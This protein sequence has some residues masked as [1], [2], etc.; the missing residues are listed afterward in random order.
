M[1]ERASERGGG[2]QPGS[3]SPPP[4]T[5]LASLG[6]SHLHPPTTTTTHQL[7]FTWLFSPPSTHTTPHTTHHL[8]PPPHT[9]PPTHP[10]THSSHH[11]RGVEGGGATTHTSTHTHT[12]PHHP[13]PKGCFSLESTTHALWRAVVRQQPLPSTHTLSPHTVSSLSRRGRPPPRA[14]RCRRCALLAR[15]RDGVAAA[16]GSRGG[17]AHETL[18]REP[19]AGPPALRHHRDAANL[20]L[21]WH[22][23]PAAAPGCVAA[24]RGGDVQARCGSSSVGGWRAP[25]I[26][27]ASSAAACKTGALHCAPAHPPPPP[28]HPSALLFL[29]LLL[30]WA[31]PVTPSAGWLAGWLGGWMSGCGWAG[32]RVGLAVYQRSLLA[33][34]AP[35]PPAPPAAWTTSAATR[36]CPTTP[37]PTCSTTR[38]AR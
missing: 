4:P 25:L 31:S 13:T 35:P 9:H 16:A 33:A 26:H 38:C 2:G 1:S 22:T 8:P 29:L 14:R 36:S 6:W 32:G 17:A 28:P 18:Q 24:Q 11:T 19:A 15:G 37:S 34:D 20:Q 3:K 27:T 12:P 5:N 7:G 23:L 10:P 21:G 30:Q